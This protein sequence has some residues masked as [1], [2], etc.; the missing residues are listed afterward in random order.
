VPERLD[1][2]AW[3]SDRTAHRVYGP[4][5]IKDPKEH[6]I[7]SGVDVWVK[8]VRTPVVDKWYKRGEYHHDHRRRPGLLQRGPKPRLRRHHHLRRRQAE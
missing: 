8:K 5:I 4:A 1:D 6:L 2:F 7:S 3:E